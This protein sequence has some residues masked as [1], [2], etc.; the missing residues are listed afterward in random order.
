MN[1]SL[2]GGINLHREVVSRTQ[3]MLFDSLK[4]DSIVIYISSYVKKSNLEKSFSY[5]SKVIS[6][7]NDSII[8]VELTFPEDCKFMKHSLIKLCPKCKR[9][10]RVIPIAYGLGIPIIDSLGNVKK[11]EKSYPGGCTVSN[12]DPSWYCERDKLKF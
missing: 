4:T 5:F 10:D 3:T 6:I 2:L 8:N 9:S 7:Q 1:V 11:E 12:C